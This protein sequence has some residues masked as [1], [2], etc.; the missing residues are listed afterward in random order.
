MFAIVDQEVVVEYPIVDLRVKFPNT[1]FPAQL[2]VGSLPKGVVKIEATPVPVVGR[3]QYVVE[4]TP[5]KNGST[6][7]Q[8]WDVHNKSQEQITSETIA[9]ATAVRNERDAMLQK[10]DWVVA[11]SVETGEPVPPA[12]SAYR[13]KLR[14]VP[15]QPG[16][17][18]DVQW[19][20]KP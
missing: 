18:W 19:P 7:L 5:V 4:G 9:K 10:T 15:A 8:T 17:P 14:D 3:N 12:Y 6:W 20:D 11:R 16:F 1:S 13:S 2:D